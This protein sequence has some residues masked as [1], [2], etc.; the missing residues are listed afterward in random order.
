MDSRIPSITLHYWK[1]EPS[2]KDEESLTAYFLSKVATH[3]SAFLVVIIG[4]PAGGSDHA[5]NKLANEIA[6][7]AFAPFSEK[8]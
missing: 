6:R 8:K 1:Y 3:T 2:R 4:T 5:P 7:L